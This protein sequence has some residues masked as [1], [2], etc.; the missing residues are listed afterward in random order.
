MCFGSICICVYLSAFVQRYE[1]L[2]AGVF[3]VYPM[4]PL[5]GRASGASLRRGLITYIPNMA[6]L[7]WHTCYPTVTTLQIRFGH[8]FILKRFLLLKYF[9]TLF[10]SFCLYSF[11]FHTWQYLSYLKLD[12]FCS[13]IN[14]CLYHI[15]LSR[16]LNHWPI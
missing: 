7:A 8:I 2:I 9:K 1:Y 10:V 14:C 16:K 6:F 11:C 12:L 3:K 5:H 13:I 15:P 4:D